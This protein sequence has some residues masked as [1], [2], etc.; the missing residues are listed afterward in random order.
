MERSIITLLTDHKVRID[1]A[2][3][4]AALEFRAI[5]GGWVFKPSFP[6]PPCT[7]YSWKHTTMDILADIPGCN[8]KIL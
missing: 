1:F 6:N 7:W 3:E 4:K 2:T 8:G 5:H